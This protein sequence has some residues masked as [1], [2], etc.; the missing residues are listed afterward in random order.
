MLKRQGW[1]EVVVLRFP[2]SVFPHQSPLPQNTPAFEFSE[3]SDAAIFET[4]QTI[5]EKYGTIGSFIHLHPATNTAVPIKNAFPDW[6]KTL[7]KQVF[8]LAKH[9]KAAKA[10]AKA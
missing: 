5:R 3:L 8:F 2:K 10:K 6:E 1:K 7:V 4:L 9:L